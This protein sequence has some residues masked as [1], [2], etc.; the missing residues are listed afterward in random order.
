MLPYKIRKPIYGGSKKNTANNETA[1]T[2]SLY[3]DEDDPRIYGGGLQRAILS[4]LMDLKSRYD[5]LPEESNSQTTRL[6]DT[7][8][9]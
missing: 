8:K 9:C 1:T 5:K 2:G 3:G 4:D 7:I 6:G